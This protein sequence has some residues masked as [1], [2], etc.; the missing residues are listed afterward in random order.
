MTETTPQVTG[1]V[2]TRFGGAKEWAW[3]YSKL[4][5]FEVCP[6]RHNE[7]DLLKRHQDTDEGDPN[8]PLAVGKR[9]HDALARRLSSQKVTL[10]AEFTEYE[11]FVKRIED[12]RVSCDGTL[13]I[14]QKYAV[15]RA[16]EPTTYFARNVWYRGI[17][18]VLLLSGTGQVALAVDWKTGKLQEDSVQLALMAQCIFSHYPQVQ[19]V[20]SRFAWLKESAETDE[21]FTRSDLR[22]LWTR[23]LPRVE[24]MEMAAQTKNYPATPNK[25]CRSY[26]PVTTCVHHGK[27]VSY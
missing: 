11:S 26:C 10:P 21:T 2:T 24:A 1:A 17:A 15:T 27:A 19:A 4:K 7:I 20:A 23:L 18:D 25:L 5:N 6:L 9:A 3:S 22:R 13:F 14:E 16:F 8:S 12:K